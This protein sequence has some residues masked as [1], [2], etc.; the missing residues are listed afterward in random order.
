MTA[1]LPIA[2]LAAFLGVFLLPGP[3]PAA[4]PVAGPVRIGVVLPLTGPLAAGGEE[5]RNSLQMAVEEINRSGGVGG[6]ALVAE[7]A[8]SRGDPATARAAVDALAAGKVA[9]VA[10]VLPSA[11]ARQAA[12][13]AEARRVPYLSAGAAADDLTRKAPRYAFRLTPPAALYLDGL[14]D[15]L[16]RMVRPRTAAII[17]RA[18]GAGRASARVL[19]G[20]A[21]AAGWTVTMEEELPA[22]EAGTGKAAVSLVRR[23]RESVPD[24]LFLSCSPA[25]A[26]SLIRSARASEV[27]MRAVVG[28]GPPFALQGFG[29]EAG[30]AAEGVLVPAAWTADAMY[31]GAGDYV[32][33]YRARFGGEP[34]E[35]GAQAHAVAWVAADA[36]RRAR[37]LDPEDVREALAAADLATAYGR[38]R[39]EAFDGYANQNRPPS[40]VLQWMGGRAVTVWPPELSAGKLLVPA[41]APRGG[42]EKGSR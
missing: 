29:L 23:M 30:E 24:V 21:E 2:P 14:V 28:V 35:R 16:V 9:L 20:I 34:G 18:G 22:G 41:H 12:A 15:L 4:G 27:A 6:R 25:D 37:S 11:E 26:S 5:A 32:E 19:S 33:D 31:S 40:L 42:G 17:S 3:A 38:V 1:R 13:A 39:F 36:L 7:V 10:G 8:D